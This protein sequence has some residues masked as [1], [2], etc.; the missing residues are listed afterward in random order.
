MEKGQGL[1]K[2]TKA[3]LLA[4]FIFIPCFL[5]LG[6]TVFDDRKYLFIGLLI[7][8]T[9]MVPFFLIFE[10]RLPKARELMLIA[11]LTAIG[12]AGR[13]AFFWLPQFKPV[14]AVTIVAGVTLGPETG[15]LV[16]AMIGFVSNFYFGQGPWTPWQMF[17][18]GLI[19][20]LG[21]LLF[22]QCK[23]KANKYTL[24]IYGFLSCFAIFGLIMN[25][26]S[27]ITFYNSFTWP[28]ILASYV[29]GF[30]FDLVQGVATVFFLFFF[31]EP[32]M[33]KI[34]RVKVKY[35]FYKE[36]DWDNWDWED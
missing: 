11:G 35:G 21:G 30:Y 15:F 18:F 28:M 12:V 17:S 36:D 29:Q 34:E 13:M 19:G 31:G 20:F 26:V 2:R 16:G 3:S 4:I 33:E 7:L 10:Q 32:M 24:S 22:Q 6:V 14:I 25:P 1:S 27:I 9:T 23:V 5:Y 8:F